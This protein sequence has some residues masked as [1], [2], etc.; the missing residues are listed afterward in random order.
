MTHARVGAGIEAESPA[1]RGGLRLHR[2]APLRPNE[3]AWS[4]ARA[5]TSSP[6][7]WVHLGGR[8]AGRVVVPGSRAISCPASGG[9]SL[10]QGDSFVRRLCHCHCLRL[11]LL[12]LSRVLSSRAAPSSL[13]LG[14]RH[15]PCGHCHCLSISACC[16]LCLCLWA[17]TSSMCSQTRAHAPTATACRQLGGTELLSSSGIDTP[18]APLPLPLH[19]RLLLPLSVSVG[20]NEFDVLSNSRTCTHCHCLSSAGRRPFAL[21]PPRFQTPFCLRPVSCLALD[22]R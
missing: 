3:S 17:A 13:E 5:G 22:L 20:C 6:C 15:P 8:A 4:F 16:C 11:H 12:S 14:H 10:C 1:L 2:E 21:P 19:L 9:R 18:H 7:C